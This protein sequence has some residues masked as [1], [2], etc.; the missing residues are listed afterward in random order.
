MTRLRAKSQTFRS[1]RNCTK[2]RRKWSMRNTKHLAIL[3]L[4]LRMATGTSLCYPRVQPP[5][6]SQPWLCWCKKTPSPPTPTSSSFSASLKSTIASKLSKLSP[7]SRICSSRDTC[8]SS[9]RS[10]TCFRRILSFRRKGR[11]VRKK[12]SCRHIMN[13]A[14][15]SSC[16]NS[17]PQS[18]SK[19]ATE[20][21]SSKRRR[22]STSQP[23]SCPT[24]NK[25]SL[26]SSLSA[27]LSTSLVTLR[28]KSSATPSTQWSEF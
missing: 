11:L 2:R 17:A 24:V 14:L 1:H 4:N 18:F 23:L 7:L 16:A 8:S 25:P 10:F 21:S 22:L 26:K 9:M 3:L 28:R 19:W 15:E 13:T 6:K 5:I 27:W 12:K 20:S